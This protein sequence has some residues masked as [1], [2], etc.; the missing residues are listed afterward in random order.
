[1][2]APA[3]S[4]D[5]TAPGAGEIRQAFLDFFAAHEHEVVSSGPLVPHNDPTL[6]FTN[7]GMVQF[8]NVFTGKETRARSRA[9]TSQKCVRAGG[10]HNDLD[11]VGYT[12]RHHTFFEM[13]GNFSFGD[14]F[15]DTAIELAWTLVTREL[16]LDPNRLWATV[17]SADDR[18]FD[19]WRKI[20]GL[21]EARI[22]RIATSDNFWA[23]GDT[24]PCGP[25]SEIFYDHG[26][27]VAGGPPGS[28]GADGDRYIEIWNLVFMQFEQREG[29][30]RI[31]L[32]RPSI[33]T[34]M[35]L[36]RIAAVL[37]GEH[38]NYET[39]LFRRLIGAVAD[40]ANTDPQGSRRASHRVIADHLRA[41]G[42]LLADG[43]TPSN[44]GRGYVLRRIMRRAMRHAHLMGAEE[45]LMWR[46]VP[47]LV[48]EMGQAF[49][50]LVRAR[51]LIE[52]TLKLEET[53]FRETLA[54]GLRLLGDETA[55]LADGAAL[56]GEVAFRL[57]DT[58][59]FPLDLTQDAMRAEGRAVDIAGFEAAMARQR[60]E[61]RKSWAGGGDAGGDRLWFDL[62]ERIGAGE[63]VG[64]AVTEAEAEIAALV[65]DG[66]S[67]DRAEAGEEVLAFMSQTPFYAESGGQMGDSGAIAVPASG[68]RI[69]VRDTAKRGG[70]MHAHIG[71]VEGGAVSVGDAVRLSIDA[72]RRL[73]LQRNHSATHLLHAALR[74][75]LGDHVT[76]KGSLVAPDRLRFDISH[77]KPVAGDDLA[78]VEAEVNREILR[79]EP[80]RTVLASPEDAVARGAV[81]LFGE[82]YGDEVRVVSMGGAD[83]GFS[84]E[85]CGGAHVARTG[86]IGLFK[87]VGESAVGAGVRRV[88]AVTGEA[89]LAWV[90]ERS[91][92]L[93]ETAAVL[94]TSP[95]AVAGRV[96]ALLEERRK[97]ERAL[98]ETRRAL[99]AGGG[100]ETA[101]KR[102]GDVAFAGRALDGVPA[103]ELR[104]MA[105][106]MKRT[107]GSGVV[108]VVSNAGGKGAV[109]VGVTA[110][111]VSRFDSVALA[112]VAA[113]ALGGKGGGGRPDLAQA[114]GPDGAAAPAALAAVEAA[115]GQPLHREE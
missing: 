42:F 63:F 1:M 108:A 104:G 25:C 6:L 115:L 109:A 58:Y 48:A 21:P 28:P 95:E 40:A 111:L 61:A 82:K 22:V 85:L 68:A 49:P 67:V 112:R 99:A 103:R 23:M 62:R 10:K 29:G 81:A 114:G 93:E 86:D 94:R 113:R 24:G 35:G 102:V 2:S 33:D 37:Q 89:A 7:A 72:P 78:A 87:L 31:D 97:L 98:A 74:R 38:D 16:G 105:D 27:A 8:K 100:A 55:R 47:A 110:D 32:P 3:G 92:A 52:E 26:P 84:V 79:N 73:A 77:P 30:E 91:R 64:Y 107:V 18:A 76:Q 4:G 46:L 96:A 15:K 12:A 17:Y 51:A 83:A 39:D 54:R 45:P 66:R 57:Y 59:G 65:V 80:V 9:A 41:A 75:R 106:E 19:L 88:E 53:R 14:Y 13:L 69:A 56:P 43:V 20:S 90:A 70:D 11:N 71:A 50:E 60:A 44:E 101:V 34:G 36:E 5:V